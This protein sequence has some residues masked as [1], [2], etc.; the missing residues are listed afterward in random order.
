MAD[1]GSEWA[2][3]LYEEFVNS[4][5]GSEAFERARTAYPDYN[6]GGEDTDRASDKILGEFIDWLPDDD[7]LT[8]DAEQDVLMEIEAGLT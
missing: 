6:S 3:K 2:K 1:V 8:D 4:D 7:V 5:E